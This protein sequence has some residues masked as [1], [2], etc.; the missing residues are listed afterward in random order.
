MP[1]EYFF[2]KDPLK[3]IHNGRGILLMCDFDGTL[4]PIQKDPEDCVMLPDIRTKLEIIVHRSNSFVAILSGRPLSDIRKRVPIEG[5]HHAGSHG[6]EISGPQ[7][8]YVRPGTV[9]GKFIIDKV[10]TRLEEEINNI[11]GIFI[12]KKRFSFALHYRMANKENGAFVRRAFYKIIS[13]NAE[14]SN[15]EVLKGKKVLEL[16]PD[17]SWDKGKAAL[18]IIKRLNK[19][20]LPVYIGDD[21][22]DE[23]VFKT[24]SGRGLTVRVGPSKRTAAQYH[25][26]HQNEISRFLEYINDALPAES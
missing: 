19:K 15:I 22:T 1:S 9:A 20:C 5:I 13:E 26:K 11:P 17:L 12:E 18:L 25:L 21:V 3:N 6:L 4:V 14:G 2:D 16:A 10:R 8:R 24:L 23:S 7:S